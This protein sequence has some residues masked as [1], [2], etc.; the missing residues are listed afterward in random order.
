MLAKIYKIKRI[1][2]DQWYWLAFILLLVYRFA[3]LSFNGWGFHYDEAQYWVWSK[4]LDWGYYSKPPMIAWMIAFQSYFWGN[5]V[6]AIKS[7]SV[8]VHGLTTLVIY[9]LSNNLFNRNVAWYSAALFL[10]SPGISFSSQ[11]ITTDVFLLLFWA[12]ALWMFVLAIQKNKL[13]YWCLSGVFSGAGLL[14][15]Y[16]MILFFPSVIFFLILS[17]HYRYLLFKPGI[18]LASLLALIIWLPNL[19][20]VY[21]HSGITFQ[22]VYEISKLDKSYINIISLLSFL[23]A[24]FAVFG[25][26]SFILLILSLIKLN[27]KNTMMPW[28]GLCVSFTLVFLVTISAQALFSRAYANWAAPSYIMASIWV[29]LTM[30][31]LRQIKWLKRAI[32]VNIILMV[33]VYHA[34]VL[35]SSRFAKD[36]FRH[37]LG[38]ETLG[39]QLSILHKKY[40][41]YGFIVDNRE[42]ISNLSYYINPHPVDIHLF[43]PD[44]KIKNYFHQVNTLGGRVHDHFIYVTEN[45]KKVE[46]IASY[47]AECQYLKTIENKRS[48]TF[49]HYYIY[50]LMDFRGYL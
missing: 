22:H 33:L 32:I 16:T 8:V 24:Q 35:I 23:V 29:A 21:Q 2:S 19:L 20:W 48:N 25:P 27:D 42:T 13:Q 31:N 14:T 10:T 9:Q 38:W 43:N 44:H 30:F 34:S 12:L 26:V 49:Y 1:I 37:V 36:P 41:N 11:A 3:V 46:E 45:P 15:K 6:F 39:N 7:M 4:N 18:W 40:P 5:S 28:L 50:Q 17:R 47:F